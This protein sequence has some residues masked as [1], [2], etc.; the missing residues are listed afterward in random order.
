MRDTEPWE[1]EAAIGPG[2]A[3]I[4]YTAGPDARPP[5]TAVTALAHRHGVPVIVDA[6]AQLPPPSNLRRFIA[7]G[8]DLV[9]FSGGKA[10]RGPQGTGMLAGRRDLIA[11]VALQ[12]LDMDVAFELWAPPAL[13]PKD[14]LAGVPRHGLGRGFKVA[15]EEIV[16]LIVA[17]RLFTVDRVRADHA[18][19]VE[20]LRSIERG[21]GNRPEVK[22]NVLPSREE[23]GFPLLKV[24]L[25]EKALGLTAREVVRRLKAGRPPIHV[26]ESEVAAGALLLHPINLDEASA[27]ILVERLSAALRS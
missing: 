14:K 19:W 11:S 17:L 13:I 22:A 20:L 1:I 23:L 10:I 21:L 5:L 9:A 2:T 16:G 26:G 8:A 25:D 6:A 7:E 15:K 18:R 24:S 12:Q 3:A 27:A 4:A